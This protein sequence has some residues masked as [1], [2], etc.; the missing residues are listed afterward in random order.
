MLS[1]RLSDTQSCRSTV[2]FLV[3]LVRGQGAEWNIEGNT[4]I[5]MDVL[6]MMVII[7]RAVAAAE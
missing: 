5:R 4:G 3:P 7:A 1:R 6:T 2:S